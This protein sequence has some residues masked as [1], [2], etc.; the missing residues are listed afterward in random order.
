MKILASIVVAAALLS[1]YAI[2]QTPPDVQAD[3]KKQEASQPIAEPIVVPFGVGTVFNATLT[4]PLDA[5]RNKAGDLVT[6][7]T[8]ETVSYERTVIFPKGTKIVGHLVRTS[9][10]RSRKGSA[11][12]V[13]FDKAIL[14]NGEEIRM[15]AGIQA[16][17]VGPHEATPADAEASNDEELSVRNQISESPRVT[18]AAEVA[19]VSSIDEPVFILPASHEAPRYASPR[20]P[21]VLPE[22][23]GGLTKGGLFTPDSQG[24]FG[25]ADIKVY[26]PVSE[27]SDGTVLV[28]TK[29]NVRLGAG[30]RLL[31]VIQPPPESDSIQQ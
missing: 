5:H 21:L 4:S 22:A 2:A 10:A 16:L 3:A 12:F 25:S 28:S 29:K 6:A 1:P 30:T 7:E 11:L 23:Q 24:A 20:E 13:Q 15:R 17:V 26:T 31:I 18:T 14:K 9:G 8:A 19:S 27:G